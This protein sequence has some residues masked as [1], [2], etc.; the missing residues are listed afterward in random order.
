MA[1]QEPESFAPSFD[2]AITTYRR[3]EYAVAAVRSCL[4][5]GPHL[6]HVIV[7]DDASGDSTEKRI[8]ALGDPRVRY[9]RRAQNGGMSAARHDAFAMSSADWTIG[10]DDDWELLPSA[11]DTFAKL[12]KIAPANTVIL[13]SR[14]RWDTGLVSPK[15][16]PTEPIDYIGQILWRSRPESLGLDHVS[17]V[18]RIAR[19]RENWLPVRFGWYCSTLFFLDA[20]QHGSSIYTEDILALQKTCMILS[21]SRGSAEQRFKRR[22]MDAAGGITV[23]KK[24]FER[25]EAG[26]LRYG[27][28]LASE[29]LT[30]GAMYHL[31]LQHRKEAAL[32]A[33]R[34]WRME[35]ANIH[36]ASMVL[37]SAL[38]QRAFRMAYKLRG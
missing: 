3:P 34:A 2:V 4:N 19:E 14:M 33:L 6:K 37:F 38:G 13:G 28:R 5:Q 8:A 21:D 9:R 24:L 31:L 35:P 27:R 10:F 32:W 15:F 23:A 16:V 25:H 36:A 22:I 20:A 12:A 7:L 11:I 26:L 18:S 30:K 29:I 1:H 17:A